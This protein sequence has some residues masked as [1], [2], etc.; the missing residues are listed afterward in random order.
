MLAV[1]LPF[2]TSSV[3]PAVRRQVL[4]SRRDRAPFVGVVAQTVV[5]VEPLRP[6]GPPRSGAVPVPVQVSV[7][8]PLLYP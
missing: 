7:G 3:R 4:R 8:V 1:G 2:L 5:V 6:L